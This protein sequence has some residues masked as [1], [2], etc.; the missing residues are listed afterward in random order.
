MPLS[1]PLKESKDGHNRQGLR[2]DHYGPFFN[3]PLLQRCWCSICGDHQL[4]GLCRR[5]PDEYQ[6][7]HAASGAALGAAETE[8]QA[9]TPVA[10]GI[11]FRP[12]QWDDPRAFGVT[13]RSALRLVD[14]VI[15]TDDEINAAM[16]TD[17]SQLSL[18][19]SQV[20]DARVSGNINAAIQALL[21]LGPG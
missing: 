4:R 16:L 14:I 5:L 13:L 17:P 11:D 8:E 2:R 7:G 3:R 18:T 20:S 1:R 6:R 15:G 10:L 9:G 19:H 12:D 21:D